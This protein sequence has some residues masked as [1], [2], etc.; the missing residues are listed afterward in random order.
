MNSKKDRAARPAYLEVAAEAVS[1]QVSLSVLVQ[2]DLVLFGHRVP[3]HDA[4]LGHQLDKLL[5]ADVR[6]QAWGEATN[7]GRWGQMK[8][9]V[10]WHWIRIRLATPTWHVDVCVFIVIDIEPSCGHKE[11]LIQ[12]SICLI[13][14]QENCMFISYIN[15]WS[16]CSERDGKIHQW[17]QFIKDYPTSQLIESTLVAT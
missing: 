16:F 13:G 2:F 3:H 8:S 14:D 1:L 5:S 11:D 10:A 7:T 12:T 17:L 4:T 15:K 9:S 6:R